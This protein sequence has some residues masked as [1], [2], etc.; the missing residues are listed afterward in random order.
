MFVNRFLDNRYA[1]HHNI[2]STVIFISVQPLFTSCIHFSLKVIILF[3]NGNFWSSFSIFS[4]YPLQPNVWK[5]VIENMS[6]S[7][8]TLLLFS[9]FPE[10]WNRR[11]LSSI[12]SSPKADPI[13]RHAQI[14]TFASQ[15]TV[16]QKRT[17]TT[18]ETWKED[19]V[20]IC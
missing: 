8:S 20:K 3:K 9:R 16:K 17:V 14:R 6:N 1:V 18:K 5:I 11:I 10:F 19:K 7:A 4:F 15:K 13:F 2:F 12:E